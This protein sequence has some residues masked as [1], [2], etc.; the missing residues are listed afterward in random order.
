[1]WLADTLPVI[2]SPM[3]PWKAWKFSRPTTVTRTS[4][5]FI[6]PRSRRQIRSGT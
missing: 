6:G 1:M 3:K 2:I 5:R 4:P